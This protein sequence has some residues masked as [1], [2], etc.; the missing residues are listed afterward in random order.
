MRIRSADL[1]R[2]GYILILV[3]QVTLPWS[4]LLQAELISEWLLLLNS[5]LTAYS[6]YRA[7]R[8]TEVRLYHAWRT[9]AL[10]FLLWS[11]VQLTWTVQQALHAPAPVL[12]LTHVLYFFAFAPMFL[13]GRGSTSGLRALALLDYLQV[14][15]TVV[16]CLFY[17]FSIPSMWPDR[18]AASVAFLQLMDVR[19][20]LLVAVIFWRSR[21]TLDHALRRL[22]Q[23]L[24]LLIAL[25]SLGNALAGF[26]FVASNGRTFGGLLNLAWMVPFAALG[27][28]ATVW[29][30]CAPPQHSRTLGASEERAE[31]TKTLVPTV[32]PLLVIYVSTKLAMKEL[33]WAG[34]AVAITFIVFGLRV[35]LL[36][37]R[38]RKVAQSLQESEHRFFHFFSNHPNPVYV[39]DMT[40]MRLVEC[41]TAAEQHYGYQ[42]GELLQLPLDQLIGY[43][44]CVGLVDKL[45]GGD[46]LMERQ[47]HLLRDG[48][49]RTM[50]ISATQVSI[51][52][53]KLALISAIDVSDRVAMEQQLQQA[54][55]M[56]AVGRL[57]G[58]IA[59]DF[60]NLLTVIKGY[61]VLLRDR[62]QVGGHAELDQIERSAD[63][64]AE[65]TR[66]LLA[67]S[68]QQVL[69]PQIIELNAAVGALLPML[70]RLLGEQVRVRTK[71]TDE[72]LFIKVD[73]TQ[74]DQVLMNLAVNARDAM[75][76]GGVLTFETLCVEASEVPRAEANEQ[77]CRFARL[78]VLDT[79]SGIPTDA[80]DRIFDPFYTTKDVGKGTGLGL[81]TVYGI[82]KQ[83]G[84]L[85]GVRSGVGRGTT[86]E[87]HFPVQDRQMLTDGS[88]TRTQVRQRLDARVLLVED[89]PS[90]RMLMRDALRRAG[91]VVTD[92]A[93]AGEAIEAIEK[94]APDVVVTDLVMPQISGFD[95]GQRVREL[96]PSA[97]VL[98][99][100]GY[101]PDQRVQEA[102][103]SGEI[104]LLHKPF[105][106][107]VLVQRVAALTSITPRKQER[108]AP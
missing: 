17:L 30:T 75:P 77:R 47:V 22:L 55:K 43:A 33:V 20:L 65:M 63:R 80:L 108:H 71:L 26:F 93:T 61:A 73:P 106:P 9:F 34:L 48:Q 87:I 91:A 69:N 35:H 45:T 103:R 53:R 86:F 70:T 18:P 95:L 66:Q 37:V 12:S 76:G 68:R 82:V 41:N 36:Y 107:L 5:S 104:E 54:E 97:A 72:K 59:H 40:T 50:E 58:G 56:Q 67:F 81:A 31:L 102:I 92:V 99:I 7:S 28:Y 4:G 101:A 88:D 42:R 105:S 79:G 85:I 60:N 25:Y 23:R 96:T 57:A 90:V 46:R 64:A 39:A 94:L 44:G 2:V 100:S 29:Q 1:E 62:A 84:G 89:E 15:V 51:D 3:L 38:E 24:T 74:L 21:T 6:C 16:T 27:I 83:S 8:G 98:Y 13:A 49:T 32:L 14:F 19:N 11:M 10:S 52:K 78:R